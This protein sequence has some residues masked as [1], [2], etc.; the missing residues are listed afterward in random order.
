MEFSKQEYWHG[1]PFP[2]PGVLP[3][4]G[5]ESS[6]AGIVWVS[7]KQ[8]Q[9]IQFDEGHLSLLPQLSTAKEATLATC[10]LKE[11]GITMHPTSG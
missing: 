3:N 5:I 6:T 7:S 1:L 10:L 9:R 8:G 11:W 2:Y 4:P